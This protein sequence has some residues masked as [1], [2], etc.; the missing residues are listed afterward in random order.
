M[1]RPPAAVPRRTALAPALLAAIVLIV[2]VALIGAGGYIYILFGVAILTLI[3]AVFAW[4]G[5][6]W[7]WLPLLAAIVVLYNPAVPIELP[8]AVRL[9]AHYLS[10][11]VL[12]IVGI[13]VK[14]TPAE[15]P[16]K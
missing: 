16:A 12:T 4:Q 7:W 8:D 15:G 13:T 5:R 1:N 2:G 6:Q 9:G 10:A 14:V 11:L 3:V